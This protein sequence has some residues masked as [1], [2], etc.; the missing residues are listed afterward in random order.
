MYRH[1]RRRKSNGSTKN[2]IWKILIDDN[3]D[4]TY[5]LKKVKNTDKREFNIMNFVIYSCNIILSLSCKIH[6]FFLISNKKKKRKRKRKGGEKEGTPF[7][8]KFTSINFFLFLFFFHIIILCFNVFEDNIKIY[9]ESG[10]WS[11]TDKY[12][13]AIV[14]YLFQF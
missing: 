11:I 4:I 6:F 8:I 13:A 10:K 3:P 14:F 1:N 9:L 7:S 2:F 12:W 5:F